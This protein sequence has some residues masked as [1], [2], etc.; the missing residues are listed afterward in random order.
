MQRITNQ[1]TGQSC[2]LCSGLS[3]LTIADPVACGPLNPPV[4]RP[5]ILSQRA[6]IAIL[7]EI[8][9]LD[10]AGQCIIGVR[11]RQ[12]NAELGFVEIGEALDFGGIGNGQVHALKVLEE[13]TGRE[14]GCAG[15]TLVCEG[16]KS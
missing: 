7:S 10:E 11:C 13:R 12:V 5:A 2:Y 1:P 4:E 16:P 14:P 9:E 8:N 3:V 15:A 6:L